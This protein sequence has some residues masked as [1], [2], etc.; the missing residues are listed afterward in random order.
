MIEFLKKWY[1]HTYQ[2]IVYSISVTKAEYDKPLAFITP[3]LL[4]L[5]LLKQY[6]HTM[7]WWIIPLL[8]LFATVTAYFLG[9]W[10]IAL[11]IPKKTTELGNMQNNE[12]MEVLRIARE[13][14]NKK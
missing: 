6:W 9:N 8:L 5:D 12:L 1:L 11:G 14:K 7:P 2:H 3:A 10:L 13:L 4:I